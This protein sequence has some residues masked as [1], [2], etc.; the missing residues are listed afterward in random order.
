VWTREVQ[1]QREKEESQLTVIGEGRKSSEGLAVREI[2][3]R[4]ARVVPEG[5]IG[6]DSRREIT[7]SRKQKCLLFLPAPLSGGGDASSQW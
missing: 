2:P 6:F 3:V 4:R 7:P 1:A 5:K